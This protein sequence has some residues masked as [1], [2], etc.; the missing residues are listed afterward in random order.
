VQQAAGQQAAE[1]QTAGQQAAVQQ[2]AGQQ[3]AVQQAAGQQVVR[4]LSAE[5]QAA[6]WQRLREKRHLEDGRGGSQTDKKNELS[7][8]RGV[9]VLY[10]SLERRP[11]VRTSSC[12]RLNGDERAAEEARHSEAVEATQAKITEDEDF[13]SVVVI[14]E[15]SLL[16]PAAKS[17]KLEDRPEA[18]GEEEE[19]E[20][21]GGEGRFKKCIYGGRD[22][23]NILSVEVR[24]LEKDEQRQQY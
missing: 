4:K 7:Q 5:Q 2:T 22:G 10:A 15:G 24:P 3:A 13:Y 8:E 11:A 6:A 17:C 9:D 18:G 16:L 23:F 14:E 21:G 19:G 12:L 1:Q 20:G